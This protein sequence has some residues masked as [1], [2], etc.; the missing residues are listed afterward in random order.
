MPLDQ[1]THTKKLRLTAVTVTAAS[2]V[3][4][5]EVNLEHANTAQFFML[6]N[7]RWTGVELG[8]FIMLAFCVKCRERIV[9]LETQC[10][11]SVMLP[12]LSL[13]PEKPRLKICCT[14]AGSI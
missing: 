11:W 3:Q 13:S 6:M 10:G 14:L 2:S 1:R 7:A 9:L 4:M 12:K 5:E 8:L